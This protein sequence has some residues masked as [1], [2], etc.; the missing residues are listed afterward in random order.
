MNIFYRD[1]FEL[2]FLDPLRDRDLLGDR[3]CWGASLWQLKDEAG[4][5]LLSGPEYPHEKPDPFNNQGLPEVFRSRDKMSGELL[6]FDDQGRG[7]VIGVGRVRID[8]EGVISVNRPCSWEISEEGSDLIWRT[9]DSL[10]ELGYTLER[11]WTIE[12]RTLTSSTRIGNSGSR[13]L[14]AQWYP[15]PFFPLVKGGTE[16]AVDPTVVNE[17]TTGGFEKINGIF[18]TTEACNTSEGCFE[19]LNGHY[20]DNLKWS[21]AHPLCG[22]VEVHGL[23]TTSYMPVWC[24]RNTISLEPHVINSIKS[25]EEAAWSLSYTFGNLK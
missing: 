10:G 3:F 7:L 6:N 4:R 25:G 17:G 21:V 20:G 12:G 11:R 19:W 18:T 5:N 22:N 9:E 8:K 14:D 13:K 15:H 2:Q 1:G 16:F 24:N 23:F